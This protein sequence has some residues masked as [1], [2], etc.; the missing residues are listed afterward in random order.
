MS[1]A[2][3]VFNGMEGVQ[4]LKVYIESRTAREMGIQI[5][6]WFNLEECAQDELEEVIRRDVTLFEYDITEVE[7][8]GYKGEIEPG[9]IGLDGLYKAVEFLNDPDDYRAEAFRAYINLQADRLDY[10]VDYFEEAYRGMWESLEDFAHEHLM[11]TDEVYR[12]WSEGFHCWRPEIDE[13][14]FRCN[15]DT[16]N[17]RYGLAVF[18]A[19]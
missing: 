7:L 5:G 6:Q 16:A 19:V 4:M 17:T 3:S 9:S 12:Q 11:E 1:P 2:F 13:I 18:Q 10:A 15:F 8:K 14:A